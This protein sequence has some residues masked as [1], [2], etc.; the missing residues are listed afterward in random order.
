[1]FILL[2]SKGRFNFHSSSVILGYFIVM[3]SCLLVMVEIFE[4]FKPH[5]IMYLSVC[6]TCL[7]KVEHTCTKVCY[8]THPNGRQFQI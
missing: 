2:W 3:F 1:M 6:L 7:K 5:S 4:I 8:F